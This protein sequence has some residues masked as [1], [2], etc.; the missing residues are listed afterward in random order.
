MI[1]AKNK[2]KLLIW[3]LVLVIVVLLG[4]VGYVFA[5]QP[6]LTGYATAQQQTGV[7]LAL[8]SVMQQAGQCQT[9]PLTYGNVTMNLVA[10]ECLQQA[11][12]Q[13]QPAQ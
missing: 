3:I 10:V 5:V 8:L 7:Q 4:I 12:E 13:A 6:A 9:V 2:T 1:M 11:Q